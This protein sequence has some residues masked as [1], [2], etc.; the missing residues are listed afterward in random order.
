MFPLSQA[1]ITLSDADV[2]MCYV[3]TKLKMFYF[4]IFK[5]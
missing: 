2:L 4:D 1:T 5:E 3:N